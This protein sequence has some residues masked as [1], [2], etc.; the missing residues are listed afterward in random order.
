MKRLQAVPAERLPEPL[1]ALADPKKPLPDAVQAAYEPPPHEKLNMARLVLWF[2]L[3]I[4]A[5]SLLFSLVI[6]RS[7]T[8]YSAIVLAVCIVGLL[9]VRACYRRHSACGG[10]DKRLGVYVLPE[11]ILQLSADKQGAVVAD[12]VPR[13][14]IEG[15]LLQPEAEPYQNTRIQVLL[16]GGPWQAYA[17][18][19]VG[20]LHPWHQEKL[21][22]WLHSGSFVWEEYKKPKNP[23]AES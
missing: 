22:H 13:E 14:E 19:S 8:L 1:R 15:F 6:N 9:Y 21:E 5:L 2:T 16:A 20:M 17:F 4:G 11:G 23:Q 18:P 7:R 12:F 3:S 10:D